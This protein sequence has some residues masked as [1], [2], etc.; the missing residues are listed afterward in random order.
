LGNFSIQ[1]GEPYEQVMSFYAGIMEQKGPVIKIL[2]NTN[3]DHLDGFINLKIIE[4]PQPTPTDYYL[5]I[6]FRK[7]GSVPPTLDESL[8]ISELEPSTTLTT[9][10]PTLVTP[11]GSKPTTL[12]ESLLISEL[13]PAVT[14]TRAI[15]TLV[16][17]PGFFP[18]LVAPA[19]SAVALEIRAF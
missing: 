9:A 18:G 16:T 11:P 2:S 17:P 4:W 6:T 3:K 13:K 14:L 10:I 15:P 1:L 12:D 5:V 7:R 19:S 8:L